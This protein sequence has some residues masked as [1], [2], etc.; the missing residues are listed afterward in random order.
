[1]TQ[2][3]ITAYHFGNTPPALRLVPA[4]ATRTWM[5]RPGF[6][7][8][9]RCLPMLLA[10]Q[11]GWCMLN[12]RA[13]RLTWNGSPH[14]EGLL[15]EALEEGSGPVACKSWFGFG[16]ATID[17]PYLIRTSQGYN[18]LVRGPA[19]IPKDG[20]APLEAL[21][22]TDWACA[23]FA[24]SWQMTRPGSITFAVDEPLALLVPVRR[25][26]LE[27]FVPKMRALASAPQL[28]Q[29]HAAW[30]ADLTHALDTRSPEFR[31]DY[32]HGTSPGGRSAPAGQHQTRLHLKSFS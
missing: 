18:T 11:H 1:M 25:G 9:K 22:E 28:A 30:R 15:V 24:I 4:R 31:R 6:E 29:D 26:E 27:S 23:S 5:D 16:L 8:S 7:F 10:S 20:I 17:I 3:H 14:V 2:P 13:V 21:V 19:N 12:N 32:V